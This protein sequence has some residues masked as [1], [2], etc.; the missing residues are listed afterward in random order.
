[1]EVC[2]YLEENVDTFV[3]DS[4]RLYIEVI[5]ALFMIYS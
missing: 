2:F 1:M 4:G 5:F 3:I